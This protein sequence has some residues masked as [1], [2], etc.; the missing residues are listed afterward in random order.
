MAKLKPHLPL[1]ALVFSLLIIFLVRFFTAMTHLDMGQDIANY[2]TTMNTVFGQDATGVGLL[3]PPLIAIPLKLFTLIFG[4][5]TG[6]KLF[7]VAVSVAIGLPFYALAKRISPPWI[8]AAIAVVF[9][10]TAPYARMLAWGYITMTGIFFIL[11]A[12]HFLIL[13]I[14]RPSVLNATVT[15]LSISLVAGLHQLSFTLLVLM[16]LV[17]MMALLLFNRSALF[18]ARK[19]LAVAAVATVLLSAPYIPIYLHLIGLQQGGGE[20][21]S[22]SVEPLANLAS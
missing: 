5:L 18:A 3:R 12:L 11:L 15:G 7:G 19:Y 2:L 4:N 6:V 10:L 8:A 13:T 16:L 20:G 21:T 9:V 22:A 1:I 17:A 14:E